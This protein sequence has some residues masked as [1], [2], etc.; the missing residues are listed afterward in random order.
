MKILSTKTHG[1]LD[2]TW[3]ILLILSPWIFNFVNGG[4]AQ[5]IPMVIGFI[6]L[7]LALVTNYELGVIKWLPMKTHLIM[8]MAVGFF[9]A[10]SPWLFRFDDIVYLPHVIFGLFAITAGILTKRSTSISHALF[11]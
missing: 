3:A 7:L 9:L 5:V 6:V 8:D 1:I 2:Y 11:G 10:I 4:A